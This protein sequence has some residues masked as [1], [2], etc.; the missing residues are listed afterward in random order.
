MIISETYEAY[1]EVTLE[2]LKLLDEINGY[3][4]FVKM[5]NG[6]E[7][8]F[9]S[10]MVFSYDPQYQNGDN[11]CFYAIR[12]NAK[13]FRV[14]LIVDGNLI[15]EIL[16]PRAEYDLSQLL[17]K[18]GDYNFEEYIWNVYSFHGEWIDP[19]SLID[20]AVRIEGYDNRPRVILN[21]E[22]QEYIIYH[23][24]IITL[25]QVFDLVEETYGVKINYSDYAWR[26]EL[27]DV[28]AWVGETTNVYGKVLTTVYVEFRCEYGWVENVYNEYGEC[29]YAFNK[30]S[31][32]VDPH[33]DLSSCYGIMYFT[34]TWVYR[35]KTG[36]IVIS[37]VNDLFALNK[38]RVE[39]WAVCEVDYQVLMGTYVVECGDRI[40]I[41]GEDNTITYKTRWDEVLVSGTF[42]VVPFGVGFALTIIECGYTIEAMWLQDY[43]KLT[44]EQICIFVSTPHGDY[45]FDSIEE[46]RVLAQDYLYEKIS[47]I[48]GEE[49]T[50]I[51][52]GN[53]YYVTLYDIEE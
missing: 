28:V 40:I 13:N 20:K 26:Y 9:S 49:Q 46:Y 11:S 48:Y 14:T 12:L 43:Y 44:E 21:V 6:E 38:E 24:D 35:A 41:I 8:P 25:R 18:F 16:V 17:S 51:A 32:W 33:I 50:E 36:D 27:D 39:L 23:D 45:F 3:E 1:G 34:G 29:G 4:G 10:S 37:D 22:G 5:P 15:G 7:V 31:T 47:N 2:E 52:L 19:Y 30:D 53:I 42:E